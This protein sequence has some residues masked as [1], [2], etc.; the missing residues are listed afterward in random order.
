MFVWHVKVRHGQAWERDGRR[1]QVVHL[2][3]H[4]DQ[5]VLVQSARRAQLFDETLKGISW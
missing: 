4:I 5:W 3:H 1:R 2:K